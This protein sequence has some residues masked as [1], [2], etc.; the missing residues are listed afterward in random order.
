MGLPKPSAPCQ[1]IAVIDTPAHPVGHSVCMGRMYIKALTLSISFFKKMQ[2]KKYCIFNNKN[3]Y[4]LK[5]SKRSFYMDFCEEVNNFL[6][7]TGVTKRRL[8]IE[9]GVTPSTVYRIADGSIKDPKFSHAV[10]LRAAMKRIM[11][12]RKGL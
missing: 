2:I 9:A 10:A 5:R 12:Y 3:I 7:E 8:A 11:A 6:N 1:L 4:F